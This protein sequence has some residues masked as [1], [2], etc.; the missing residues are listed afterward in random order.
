MLS[1]LQ[2]LDWFDLPCSVLNETPHGAL[3]TQVMTNLS[4]LS[5]DWLRVAQASG[6][7]DSVRVGLITNSSKS[8]W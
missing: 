3:C 2:Q 8:C 5:Q 1:L 6:L 7:V 4:F